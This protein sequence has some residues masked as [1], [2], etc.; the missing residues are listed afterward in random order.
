MRVRISGL[1]ADVRGGMLGCGGGTGSGLG[2]GVGNS[3]LASHRPQGLQAA[4]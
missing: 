4:K 3:Q 2:N 1:S